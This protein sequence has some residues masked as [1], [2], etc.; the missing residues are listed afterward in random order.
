M[1]FK[2]AHKRDDNPPVSG[3]AISVL[4]R[5]LST[6]AG[7][8]AE[9]LVHCRVSVWKWLIFPFEIAILCYFNRE[10]VIS[11]WIFRFSPRFSGLNPYLNGLVEGNIPESHGISESGLCLY[12][13]RHGGGSAPRQH[14]AWVGSCP[15]LCIDSKKRQLAG[16]SSCPRYV[17]H[18]RPPPKKKL[19]FYIFRWSRSWGHWDVCFCLTCKAPC[20]STIFY[21]EQHFRVV[22]L[23]FSMA[24]VWSRFIPATHMCSFFRRQTCISIIS[25]LRHNLYCTKSSHSRL[26]EDTPE[27]FPKRLY[28]LARCAFLS[29]LDAWRISMFNTWIKL[30]SITD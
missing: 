11:Q 2:I 4:T 13:L 25:M 9:S 19:F 24:W 30:W 27:A 18:S 10:M 8:G 6:F 17:T 15:G 23:L 12:E 28:W 1:K 26:L 16:E 20:I 14:Q 21:M 29:R 7:S 22:W 5:I 3:T